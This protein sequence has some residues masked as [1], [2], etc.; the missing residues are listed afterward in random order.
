MSTHHQ[1]KVESSNLYPALSFTESSL[2]IFFSHVFSL[3]QHEIK[4]SLSLAF[5]AKKE[6]SEIHGRFLQDYRP[7]DVITFPADEIEESAGEIL[8][9]VDQAILESCDRAIPLAEEL[10]LYLIHG[11][12][13]LIGFDDIEESDREIMRREEKSAM[14]HIRELGAWPDFLLART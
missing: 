12:L 10:S 2:A 6:H 7:T 11:W 1:P 14:D 9:S 3:H 8:I 13:H 4:G 5:L